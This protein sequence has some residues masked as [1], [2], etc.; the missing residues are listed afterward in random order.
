MVKQSVATIDLWVSSS[1][2]SNSSDSSSYM[3]SDSSFSSVKGWNCFISEAQTQVNKSVVFSSVSLN[4]LS[5]RHFILHQ[6]FVNC[7]LFI[8]KLLGKCLRRFCSITRSRINN[9]IPFLNCLGVWQCLRENF[10][11]V[12]VSTWWFIMQCKGKASQLFLVH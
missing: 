5:N 9:F 12:G 1:D 11:H 7:A 2:L 6:S 3:Y 10:R 4:L 8:L